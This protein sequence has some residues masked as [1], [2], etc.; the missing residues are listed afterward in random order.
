MHMSDTLISLDV[1]LPFLVI[2]AVTLTVSCFFT[3][4]Q[5]FTSPKLVVLM[6]VLGAF[7]F[8]AQM[9]NF[10]IPGTGASGHIAGALLLAILLGPM[11]A[12]VVLASVLIIQALLFADGG[13]LA[14]GTNIF[15]LGIITCFFVY[16]FIW[17]PLA[18]NFSSKKRMVIAS[19]V[20]GCCA[21]ILGSTSVALE[22]SL[23][24][25]TLLPLNKFLMLIVP[26]HFVIGVVE[27]ILTASLLFFLFERHEFK[28]DFFKSST[29]HERQVIRLFAILATITGGGLTLLASTYPDGLEWSVKQLAKSGHLVTGK[30]LQSTTASIQHS[31]SIMPG[32]TLNG[33]NSAFAP[34][35]AGLLG[36]LLTLLII[37]GG[38]FI[39]RQLK[40]RS[41][42]LALHSTEQ[43]E[44]SIKLP[45]D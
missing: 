45:Q 30:T 41:L 22:T 35:L 3:Q 15:N 25:I 33:I 29:Q 26:V 43:T 32:Y 31:T 5:T 8:A 17:K 27:G 18:G 9:I 38:F 11:P 2:S 7:I 20:A 13:L 39:L 44:Q 12:F 24:G 14:L 23:S 6:A 36:G 4:K 10:T 28:G 21:M 37:L 16:P 19:V 1:A 42:K 40:N 34:S